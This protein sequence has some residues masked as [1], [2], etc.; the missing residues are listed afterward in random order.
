MALTPYPSL[1]NLPE[2]IANGGKVPNGRLNPSWISLRYDL[3][4][5]SDATIEGVG[6]SSFS[7]GGYGT[8]NLPAMS[9]PIGNRSAET[10]TQRIQA[11]LDTAASGPLGIYW[12]VRCSVGVSATAGTNLLSA[13]FMRR[14]GNLH[15]IGRPGCGVILRAQCNSAIFSNEMPTFGTAISGG[16]TDSQISSIG[17]IAFSDVTIENLYMNANSGVITALTGSPNQASPTFTQ[18]Y[19]LNV[20]RMHG[21]QDITLQGCKIVGAGGFHTYWGNW[22]RVKILGCTIDSQGAG[23][24]LGGND[25]IH[26][27]G[28]GDDATIRD[29]HLASEDDHIAINTADGTDEVEFNNVPT[30]G[31]ITNVRAYNT[32]VLRSQTNGNF[33]RIMPSGGCVC[34]GHVFSGIRGSVAG[35]ALVHSSTVNTSPGTVGTVDFDDV[36]IDFTAHGIEI[37]NFGVAL[38]GISR[39]GI[40]G[41]RRSGSHLGLPL[42]TVGQSASNIDIDDMYV[43]DDG[44]S[45]TDKP[46]IQVTTGVTV[47]S[48]TAS[49]IHLDGHSGSQNMP[50]LQVD[51]GANVTL[52]RVSNAGYTNAAALVSNTGTIARMIASNIDPTINLM[53]GSAPTNA[54][55]DYFVP[56]T[57]FTVTGPSSGSVSVAST[58]FTITPNGLYTGTITM[59]P[60]GGGLS[61]PVVKTF[62]N[63]SAPQTFTIDPTSSG[64]VT[65]VFTNSGGLTDPSN[66]SYVA[67]GFAF[68]DTFTGT[69]A[70]AL[71]GNPA[72][73][74][75]NG[76][77]DYTTFSPF[78]SLVYKSGGGATSST[79]SSGA[80]FSTYPLTGTSAD[81]TLTAT[82]TNAGSGTNV[83]FQVRR[84]VSGTDDIAVTANY[85]S[86]L[87][88]VQPTTS[89]VDGT[90][91]SQSATLT[92]GVSHT[93]VA[94][95]SGTSITVTLDG[96]PLAALTS[97]TIPAATS[98]R[99]L[100][101]GQI[102]GSAGDVVFTEVKVLA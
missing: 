49:K 15:V 27:N 55:G 25:A 85:A 38:A 47:G 18:T 1:A 88:S 76:S 99:V 59:T 43:S 53:A 41:V 52:A 39:I 35:L 70:A 9:T 71:T 80:A 28:P 96:S 8:L 29:C 20:I 21:V 86:G 73:P 17:G 19:Y 87:V 91:V 33:T 50:V 78:P 16:G 5:P 40:R 61:T 22:Q 68:D 45:G 67:G 79:F 92:T 57:A 54:S 58:N 10:V 13:F 14:P 34:T 30:W 23:G 31:G 82:F 42:M 48:F 62:T 101:F 97:L 94:V 100:L 3:G 84:T 93:I 51:S 95:L 77:D 36:N 7:D 90:V 56:A 60:S 46:Q 81:L 4:I 37:A 2:V 102:S 65:L 6:S 24:T 74:T 64:T 12:D 32:T 69:A 72:S 26:F 75:N 63:S 44:T 89:S 98:G 66:L 83:A 11:A